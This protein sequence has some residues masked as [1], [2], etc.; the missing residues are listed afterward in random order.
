MKKSVVILIGII[1]V[2]AIALV[3]FFGLK[4]KVFDEVVPVS[5]IE[6]ISEGVEYNP[7]KNSYSI[8]IRPDEDGVRAFRIKY[9]VYPDD[10]T[11]SSVS[12]TIDSKMATVDDS[13][14]VVFDRSGTATVILTAND[15]TGISTKIVIVSR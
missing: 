8:V 4:H 6:I 5:Q 2:A 1:Y 9:R 10:A 7:D 13:G 15:G 11:E 14:L 3:S 12:F